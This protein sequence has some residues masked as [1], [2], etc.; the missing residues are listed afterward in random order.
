M[1]I[2]ILLFVVVASTVP[3]GIVHSASACEG[4][5]HQ[6][7]AHLLQEG[8]IAMMECIAIMDLGCMARVTM[9]FERQLAQLSPPCQVWV[10]SSMS[11][12]GGGGGV[13][14]FG[15]VCCDESQCY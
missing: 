14:C 9:A 8:E 3:F 4:T 10:R 1:S 2:R 5:E 15:G 7:A 12:G 13:H 11:T 6:R